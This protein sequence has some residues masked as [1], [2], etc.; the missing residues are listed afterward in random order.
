LCGCGW[1]GK[2]LAWARSAQAE[3][4]E[5]RDWAMC[6]PFHLQRHAERQTVCR[7][8]CYWSC[9][10]PSHLGA[11]ASVTR[12]TAPCR[13]GGQPRLPHC[14]D[15]CSQRVTDTDQSALRPFTLPHSPVQPPVGER[16]RAGDQRPRGDC[17]ERSTRRSLVSLS[18]S[19]LISSHSLFQPDDTERSPCHVTQDPTAALTLLS[20]TK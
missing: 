7:C 17:G 11:H 6:S 2:S 1:V 10:S 9:A 5:E 15:L 18:L 19:H 3:G 13:P 8:P 4:Q 16:G 14:G 20:T 12:G